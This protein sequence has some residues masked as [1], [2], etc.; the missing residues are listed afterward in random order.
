MDRLTA[1]AAKLGIK[2]TP[3]QVSGFEMYY[4]ELVEWNQ[5]VNLTA[6]VDYEGVQVRH[7]L[8]S[9]TVA[10]LIGDHPLRLIDIGSGA[11]FPG[12][13]LKIA[14]PGV[15]LTLVESVNKKAAFLRHL[16]ARLN[17][18]G[19]ELV[20]GRAETL[21]HEERYRESYDIALSRGV[22]SLATLA[23]LSLPFCAIGGRFIAMKK[24]DIG[25]EVASSERAIEMLGGKL[26]EVRLVELDEFRGE[27][28]WLVLVDKLEPTP[29][30]YPR[31]PGIPR[32]RPL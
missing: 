16:I 25:D 10:P 4:R 8:D 15:E 1:G 32:K 31:R 5:R 27:R 28:R 22:A 9:L 12:I 29:D 23:E 18:E 14:C 6:I 24:G 13:P 17:L 11:G 21:A 20:A 30:K 7:F 2:L 26:A 19:V 3:E